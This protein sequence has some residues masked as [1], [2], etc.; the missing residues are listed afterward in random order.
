M[1]GAIFSLCVGD[2]VAATDSMWD[3]IGVVNA[4]SFLFVIIL[5]ETRVKRWLRAPISRA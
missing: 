2:A 1:S 3:G 5:R 4:L